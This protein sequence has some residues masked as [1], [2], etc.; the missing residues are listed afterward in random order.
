MP[1]INNLFEL[2]KEVQKRIVLSYLL[3]DERRLS[4]SEDFFF[5]YYDCRK[6]SLEAK[7]IDLLKKVSFFD[8]REVINSNRTTIDFCNENSYSEGT[9]DNV[10]FYDI[11]FGFFFK[12]TPKDGSYKA[13]GKCL[14][15]FPN[16]EIMEFDNW[17][18]FRSKLMKDEEFAN[19]LRKRLY[20]E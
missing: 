18:D 16:K 4:M 11:E 9:F 8:K 20:F 13:N 15:H 7:S 12:L 5:N 6:P 14:L 10:S 17:M 19:M 2:H 3:E 1:N